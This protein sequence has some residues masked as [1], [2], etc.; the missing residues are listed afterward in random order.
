M[1]VKSTGN[2]YT[3]RVVSDDIPSQAYRKYFYLTWANNDNCRLSVLL[4]PALVVAVE[5][6]VEEESQLGLSWP[7][8]T[9]PTEPVIGQVRSEL[10]P[11]YRRG[12]LSNSTD[13]SASIPKS[14]VCTRSLSESGF[15]DLETRI[16]S[17]SDSVEPV[18]WSCIGD[19][20]DAG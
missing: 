10:Q 14:A 19:F 2:P 18:D 11:P 16:S 4:L 6:A 1:C 9:S 12:T 15:D 17:S 7:S 8:P 20:V 5:V 13:S 3:K